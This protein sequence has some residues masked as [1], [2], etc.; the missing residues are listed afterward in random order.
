[1]AAPGTT[2]GTLSPKARILF[3]LICFACGIMPALAAFDIGPLHS[4]DIEG[5]RWL[6]VVAGGIFMAGGI[7]LMLGERYRNS[8]GSYGLFALMI[9]SLAAIAN[10]VAFGPGPRECTIAF[11]GLF[12]EA[13]SAA[14]DITCRAGFGVGA[15]MLDGF[16]LTMV[17]L[18]LRQ[19]TG[20]S[21]PSALIEKLGIGLMLLSLAPILIPLLLILI[22]K[23]CIE[24]SVTWC[25]T[26]RWPR[27]ESFI[28]RMKAKRAARP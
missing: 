22:A 28:A 16:V 24:A 6:G 8:V 12:F 7:A 4:G 17:A 25:R 27:N 18:A 5:P 3:G 19:I 23:S 21:A 11:A 15:G 1:M 20:S 2:P 26:G 13:G 9:G 10:W 14:N